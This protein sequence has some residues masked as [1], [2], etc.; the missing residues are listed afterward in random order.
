MQFFG[1]FNIYSN[2]VIKFLNIEAYNYADII[3]NQP[4]VLLDTFSSSFS[5]FTKLIPLFKFVLALFWIAIAERLLDPLRA[6]R[7]PQ[8]E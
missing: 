4:I 2:T 1:H 5:S 6:M 3:I 7:L 8:R